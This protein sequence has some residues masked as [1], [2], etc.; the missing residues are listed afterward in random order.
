MLNIVQIKLYLI[1]VK[2]KI[3]G[4]LS[5]LVI[6]YQIQIILF[7]LVKIDVDLVSYT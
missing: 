5:L 6:Y 4:R 1:I 7:S 3:C 2:T